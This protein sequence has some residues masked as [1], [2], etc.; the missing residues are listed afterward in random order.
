M[1]YHLK[2]TIHQAEQLKIR[3]A[4]VYD[5][6]HLDGPQGHAIMYLYC[7]QDAP[8]FQKDIEDHLNISKSVASHLIQRMKR[9]GFIETFP[10]AEDKRH[11]VIQLTNLGLK[12]CSKIEDFILMTKQTVLDGISQD[13]IDFLH[14]IFLKIDQNILKANELLDQKE[15]THD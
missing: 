14:K 8:V 13:E 12:K 6:Q 7:H 11:K 5:I 3:Y 2:H 15:D 4:N 1:L 9:N 10:Y